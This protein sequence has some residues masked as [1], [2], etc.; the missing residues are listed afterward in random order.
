MP[1]SEE[2][3]NQLPTGV[4]PDAVRALR[5]A[6]WRCTPP[7]TD[8]MGAFKKAFKGFYGGKDGE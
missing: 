1:E 5:E 2:W 7:S 3:E 4:T 6:G 8:S